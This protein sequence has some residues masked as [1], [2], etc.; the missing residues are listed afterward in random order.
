M[1]PKETGLMAKENEAKPVG[2]G[3]EE[4]ASG[5]VER[6]IPPDEAQPGDRSE[7]GANLGGPVDVRPGAHRAGGVAHQAPGGAAAPPDHSGPEKRR[8]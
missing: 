8:D 3:R 6:P 1:L 7:L 2:A 5:S 4:P